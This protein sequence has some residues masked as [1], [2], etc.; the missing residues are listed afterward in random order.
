MQLPWS[1]ALTRCTCHVCTV[2]CGI[3]LILVGAAAAARIE[4][5]F[6]HCYSHDYLARAQMLSGLAT[7]KKALAECMKMGGGKNGCRAT[8]KGYVTINQVSCQLFHLVTL[9]SALRPVRICARP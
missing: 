8:R 3:A 7:G 6:D 4:I 5:S 1:A 9:V 2:I